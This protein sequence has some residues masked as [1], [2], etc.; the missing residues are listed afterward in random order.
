VD[1]LIKP[2]NGRWD[3][4]L[5]RSLFWPVDVI[6]ILEIPIYRNREDLVAWHFNTNGLFTV[7]SAYHCQGSAKF[8]SK[9]LVATAGGSGSDFVGRICENF[10]FLA[11]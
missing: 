3:E 1:E 9:P 11:R 2:V 8:G 10:L 4:A 5:I 6:R 7:K